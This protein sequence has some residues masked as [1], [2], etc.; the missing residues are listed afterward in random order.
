M[1]S[2]R[3]NFLAAATAATSLGAMALHRDDPTQTGPTMPTTKHI[4]LIGDSIFDNGSYVPGKPSVIEQLQQRLGEQGKAF[5]LA[6]D[7]DVTTDVAGQ[8]ARLPADVTHL[9]VSVGGNDALGHTDLLNMR[10]ENSA[11]LL[12]ALARVHS[13]FQAAY[14]NMLTAVKSRQ[15]PTAVCTIYDSN[16]E[17]PKKTL[18]DVALSIFN[19][20]ILRCAQ[21]AKVPVVDLRRIFTAPADYANAIEPSEIGGDKMALAI[22]NMADKH[23]FATPYTTFYS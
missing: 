8:L 6:N 7:G 9:V 19:D 16:F 20:A 3:R 5:L 18:A 13:Q 1:D 2:T 12:A 10:I 14:A 15:I 4:A 22:I 23:D 21:Q 11:E 17:R